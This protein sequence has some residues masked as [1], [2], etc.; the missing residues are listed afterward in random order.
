MLE[1]HYDDLNSHT[2][3]QNIVRRLAYTLWQKNGKSHSK[4]AY[5]KKR[6]DLKR[7][8][9]DLVKEVRDKNC[10][11]TM[12]T[13]FLYHPPIVIYVFTYANKYFY[14]FT[15]DYLVQWC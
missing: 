5:L 13:L 15:T 2:E 3:K 12:L 9:M 8:R 11:G 7:H 10:P 1:K 14:S 6:S 4:D